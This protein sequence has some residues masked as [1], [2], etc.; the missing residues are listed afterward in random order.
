MW[1]S[2]MAEWVTWHTRD[3]I[4][5]IVNLHI[6]HMHPYYFMPENYIF[7]K[8]LSIRYYSILCIGGETSRRRGKSPVTEDLE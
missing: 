4:G 3:L 6:M 2:A 7:I 8:G 5:N 1:N